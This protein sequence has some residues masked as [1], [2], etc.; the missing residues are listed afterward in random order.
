MEAI[1]RHGG[2][3]RDLIDTDDE[4]Y[5]VDAHDGLEAGAA[6]AYGIMNGD[7]PAPTLTTRCTTPSSG[8]FT[9]PDINRGIT[10][11]EAALLMTF[12]RWFELP[13]KNDAAERVVGNAVPPKLVEQ[14]ANT[15]SVYLRQATKMEQ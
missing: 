6:S 7:E 4:E 13:S 1:R 9:H 2:S 14:I 15:L 3:W 10:F 12:P 5:I 11:R 8:R